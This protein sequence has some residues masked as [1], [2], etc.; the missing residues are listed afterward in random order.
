MEVSEEV[1]AGY[2]AAGND[3]QRNPALSAAAPATA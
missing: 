3:H 2:F 1:P